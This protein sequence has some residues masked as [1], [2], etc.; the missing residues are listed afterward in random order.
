M[1]F[2]P[3]PLGER[4]R[5]A[6]ERIQERFRVA[7]LPPAFAML[8]RAEYGLHDIA[9][10]LNRMMG[11]DQLPERT[12][13][14][15]GLG[16]A[17]A[18]GSAPA[19]EFFAA[20]AMVAGRTRDEVHAAIGLATSM[21]LYNNYVRFRH[22]LPETMRRDFEGFRPG[23]NAEA[24]RFSGFSAVEKEAI[25]IAVS[26]VNDCVGCV[27]SHVLKARE[28]GMSDRQIDEAIKVVAVAA[29]L[30]RSLAALTR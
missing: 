10:N 20:A 18:T 9:M 29:P 2:D 14:L 13:L 3:A 4:G 22:Q 28:A 30:A 24:T 25:C 26:S 17:V 21:G 5:L 8:A 15:V 1:L 27:E 23:L 7:E 6:L 16:V 12:K 11:D 19:A